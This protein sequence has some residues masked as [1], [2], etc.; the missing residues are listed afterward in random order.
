MS[1]VQVSRVIG[2]GP[3]PYTVTREEIAGQYD[4]ALH[5]DVRSLDTDYVKERWAA[6]NEALNSDRSGALNDVVLTRWKLASID[7]NLADLAMVDMQAKNKNEVEEE[8]TALAKLMLGMETVPPEGANAR[9][10][11]ET[12]QGEIQRNPKAA[13]QYQQDAMFQEQV[14]ARLS[15]WEFDLTQMDNARIGATGWQP[16]AKAPTASEQLSAGMA[17]AA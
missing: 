4:L 17:E 1:P 9:V 7:P 2:S 14:N 3:M 10:R 16:A 15:K 13:A 8:R 5:F 6:I 11:L 12:L